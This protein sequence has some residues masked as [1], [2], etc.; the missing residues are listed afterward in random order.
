MSSVAAAGAVSEAQ[1]HLVPGLPPPAYWAAKAG[2][3]AFTRYI[4][5]M[6]IPHGV[7]AN[8]VRPGQVLT[9]YTTQHTPGHHR[10]EAMFEQVQLTKG[11]GYPADVA[12]LVSF[13]ASDE[14]RFI[15]GQVIDI[16]GGAT[17]KV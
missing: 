17:I 16:D 1:Q 2:M 15:N 8:A 7:R 4:A 5:T 13:L 6:G 14:S 3:E 11:P 10:P 12:N 9:P